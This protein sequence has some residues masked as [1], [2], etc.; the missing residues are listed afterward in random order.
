[1]RCA[2][3]LG[4]LGFLSSIIL[5][6]A[7]ARPRVEPDTPAV[8]ARG[9]GSSRALVAA[10]PMLVRAPE[11]PALRPRCVASAYPS[12]APEARGA[13]P[14]NLSLPAHGML[15]REPL[16]AVIATARPR[17]AQCWREA[18]ARDAELTEGH[19]TMRF[20]IVPDGT[21]ACAES[22]A[23]NVADERLAGCVATALMALRFAAFS[24][25]AIT[26]S[27]PFALTSTP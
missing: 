10:P 2:L 3:S 12:D 19:L 13:T 23:S 24:R 6:C 17:I 9:A 16:R 22:V 4:T 11:E 8:L 18:M 7:A 20:V 1:M 25:G 27:Y 5:G 15:A 26:V 21:V 14:K